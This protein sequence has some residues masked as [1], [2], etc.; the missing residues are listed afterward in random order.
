MVNITK[1]ENEGIQCYCIMQENK[2]QKIYDTFLFEDSKGIVG[3][4]HI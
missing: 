3:K 4:L 2:I 1:S